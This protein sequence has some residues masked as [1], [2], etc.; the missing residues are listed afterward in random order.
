M[1]KARMF[2]VLLVIAVFV[3]STAFAEN[4]LN[5]KSADGKLKKEKDIKIFDS[6]IIEKEGKGRINFRNSFDVEVEDVDGNPNIYIGNNIIAVNTEE[7]P[8]LNQSAIITFYNVSFEN[9]PVIYY[10][11]EFTTNPSQINR[12]C[13]KDICTNINYDDA[14]GTLTFDVSHFSSYAAYQWAVGYNPAKP[15]GC[16]VDADCVPAAFCAKYLDCWTGKDYVTSGGYAFGWGDFHSCSYRPP[17]GTENKTCSAYDGRIIKYNEPCPAN[18]TQG[19]ASDYYDLKIC[20]KTETC[21]TCEGTTA[22]DKHYC[23]ASSFNSCWN[24][25]S[26]GDCWSY[27]QTSAANSC[28]TTFQGGWGILGIDYGTPENYY[29]Q[30]KTCS[31]P[32]G[33][34]GK[35]FDTQTVGNI[36]TNY[37]FNIGGINCLGSDR[38]IKVCSN[39]NNDPCG[40]WEQTSIGCNAERN[41]TTEGNETKKECYDNTGTKLD[42]CQDKEILIKYDP[43]FPEQVYRVNITDMYGYSNYSNPWWWGLRGAP[44]TTFLGVNI[45][46]HICDATQVNCTQSGMVCNSIKRACNT[47]PTASVSLLP[48]DPD[49]NDSTPYVGSGGPYSNA[50]LNC[51]ATLSDADTEDKELHGK[52]K[53][54]GSGQTAIMSGTETCTKEQGKNSCKIQIPI[55]S[56]T[57]TKVNDT[58]NCTVV[59]NDNYDDGK[60]SY[61]IIWIAPDSDLYIMD[62]KPI[63]VIE[64]APLVKNKET[65]VRVFANFTSFINLNQIDNVVVNL[66]IDYYDASG[67]KYYTKTYTSNP[68]TIKKGY[69]TQEKFA[70]DD[71]FN[72]NNVQPPFFEGKIKLTAQVDGSNMLIETNENNIKTIEKVKVAGLKKTYYHEYIPLSIGNWAG[73]NM[74]DI[75]NVCNQNAEFLLSV[76]PLSKSHF[77]YHCEDVSMSRSYQNTPIFSEFFDKAYFAR[78]VLDLSYYAELYSN[79]DREIGVVPNGILNGLEG[80]KVPGIDRAVL[81][82][83]DSLEYT[84]AHEIGHTYGFCDEYETGNIL[85]GWLGECGID[86][87]EQEWPL[88]Y[89][90]ANGWDVVNNMPKI[91]VNP[92]DHNDLSNNY[93]SFMGD[94]FV[95]P[96]ITY[97]NYARLLSALTNIPEDPKLLLVGGIISE[98]GLFEMLPWYELGDGYPDEIEVGNYTLELF[99][100]DNEILERISFNPSFVGED[101]I[102]Y[103]FLFS[104]PYPEG[105]EKARIKNK[106]ITLVEISKGQPP[107]IN[108]K[109]IKK[110]NGIYEVEWDVADKNTSNLYYSLGYSCDNVNWKPLAINIQN[111]SFS[112]SK[113]LIPQNSMCNLKL[114]A[115]AGLNSVAVNK[116]FSGCDDN[117]IHLGNDKSDCHTDQGQYK[118]ENKEKIQNK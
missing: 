2:L 68:K 31:S 97:K 16:S 1:K 63:Q 96:W 36:T 13:P 75:S 32:T 117:G 92:V 39:L 115:T 59:P 34:L 24:T 83:E 14:T 51:T 20:S 78:W 55:I 98:E 95:S 112:F 57:Y 48:K 7:L 17:A 114:I 104:I 52:Y 45:R 69:T 4:S 28:D 40:E 79:A 106:E 41:E 35:C 23:T 61:N 72:F 101:S 11:E 113:L 8:E 88:G 116:T 38:N 10:S 5:E 94:G 86:W 64:D 27:C 99:S 102:Y 76:Y 87:N 9:T 74:I 6:K 73:Q 65:M 53:V 15:G 84:A 71:T 93:Y 81:I 110:N 103:L 89:I 33:E 29:C 58:I 42:Y 50:D 90:A 85:F 111:T 22:C 30:P 118:S 91:S 25:C 60:M 37:S 43:I 44:S 21:S 56:N 66:T 70:A 62:I 77:S 47:L 80:L 12:P 109:P 67:N 107:I 18:F 26:S 105:V 19:W 46:E 108:I 100:A 49:M 54:I 82:E 3:I